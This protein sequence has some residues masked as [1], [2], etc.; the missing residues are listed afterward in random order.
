MS[1]PGVGDEHSDHVVS[2][3]AP[4]LQHAS[5]GT[6]PAASAERGGED[7]VPSL[8]PELHHA[9]SSVFTTAAVRAV[10]A[11]LPDL[12]VLTCRDNA[13]FQEL[14]RF[15]A[16]GGIASPRSP[17]GG[18]RPMR[19]AA[20]VIHPAQKRPASLD[21]RQMH[22]S[23]APQAWADPGSVCS[24]QVRELHVLSLQAHHDS[25]A[26]SGPST[27]HTPDLNGGGRSLDLAAAGARAAAAREA[28]AG[29]QSACIAHR[30]QPSLLP[31]G[32]DLSGQGQASPWKQCNASSFS[33]AG[34]CAA[35]A[36]NAAADDDADQIDEVSTQHAA[37]DRFE[38]ISHVLA[39]EASCIESAHNSDGVDEWV[40]QDRREIEP[41]RAACSI[42][43]Q[44]PSS[45]AEI[46]AQ[47]E[48]TE[49]A[50][51]ED[52]S[53][54]S[55]HR[56]DSH[57]EVAGEPAVPKPEPDPALPLGTTQEGMQS[58]DTSPAGGSAI[59]DQDAVIALKEDL[60]DPAVKVC[61]AD[62]LPQNE[63]HVQAHTT[64]NLRS[65]PQEATDPN[66]KPSLMPAE[67]SATI[68]AT[69]SCHGPLTH[70]S[71][72]KGGLDTTSS[73]VFPQYSWQIADDI[74]V[75]VQTNVLQTNAP[76]M[77]ALSCASGEGDSDDL[78]SKQHHSAWGNASDE[79]FGSSGSP[80][81][82]S[83]PSEQNQVT[84]FQ[85]S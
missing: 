18:V 57:V 33:S 8:D 71:C 61:S 29:A 72:V 42:D 2:G 81:F 34:S 74:E 78:Q 52:S 69:S 13:S 63:D 6:G 73:T 24:R 38:E 35:A 80:S 32:V 43:N 30:E 46:R 47:V 84:V 48:G 21:A 40:D 15:W 75:D 3:L 12:H 53:L 20:E 51:D 7:D 79:S 25:D 60:T 1:A 27:P 82:M 66:S 83:F 68:D 31:E 45:P 67:L 4:E 16:S 56:N 54:K 36:D 28:K 64:L 39:S 85:W 58:S 14:Q 23:A 10:S 62:R 70:R 37:M 11:P 44:E 55:S 76:Q 49:A 41:N 65:F 22:A 59:P 5:T 9:R 26:R 77:P 19:H 17:E 50:A